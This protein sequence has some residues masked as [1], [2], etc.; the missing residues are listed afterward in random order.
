MKKLF[1]A[2]RQYDLEQ[3]RA[4]IEASPEAIN[5][6]SLPPPKKDAGQSPL[7]VAIKICAFDIAKL[8]IEHGADVN[9]MESEDVETS[10]RCPLLHDAVGAVMFCLCCGNLSSKEDI[11]KH[12]ENACRAFSVFEMLCGRGA[13][14]NK[15]ASNGMSALNACVH[16][17]ERVLD[18]RK[19]YPFTQNEA[20]EYLVKMLDTL[21][22]YGADLA[23]WAVS[24]HYPPADEP[25]MENRSLFIDDFVPKEDVI[26]EFTLRGKKHTSVQKGD[27]DRTAHTRAVIQKYVKD[28]MIR[29]EK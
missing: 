9:F 25:E 16:A 10:L 20:E 22:H 19:A 5:S 18:N 15:E 29:I 27:T 4:V 23:K 26:R 17:A 14:V 13:D 6:V 3:V 11:D 1:K 28:R 21:I 2:I 7:Q 8:L 12:K 24:S